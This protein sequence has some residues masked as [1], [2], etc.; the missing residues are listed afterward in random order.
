MANPS[1]QE[2]RIQ[3]VLTDTTNNAP[4]YLYA[5]QGSCVVVRPSSGDVN[6]G[7]SVIEI[8]DRRFHVKENFQDAVRL[9]S[10]EG[11][12][13]DQLFRDYVARQ[14]QLKRVV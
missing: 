5:S 1:I 3:A 7:G 9:I 4:I 11:V 8:Q 2:T 14:A 6:Q 12:Q 10:G 13:T